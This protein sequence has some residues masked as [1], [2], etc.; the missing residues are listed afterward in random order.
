MCLYP[1]LIHTHTHNRLLEA[2]KE[3]RALDTSRDGYIDEQEFQ[4]LN[5]PEV[6]EAAEAWLDPASHQVPL[7]DRIILG[8]VYVLKAYRVGSRVLRAW[9][10]DFQ[11]LI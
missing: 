5:L 4:R 2:M 1:N 6:R 3:V 9:T 10:S 7:V 8:V 11:C